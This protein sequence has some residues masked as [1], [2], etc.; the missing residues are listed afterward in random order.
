M[1][2][3]ALITLAIFAAASFSGCS[4]SDKAEFDSLPDYE[5]Y[6]EYSCGGAEITAFSVGSDG[7]L[8]TASFYPNNPTEYY[9][10]CF[11]M[12]GAK[13]ASLTTKR[14]ISAFSYDDNT[15][16]GAF[17]DSGTFLEELDLSS[18]EYREIC[19]LNEFDTIKK[20]QSD[21]SDI[22]VMGT[23]FDR[24][25]LDGEYYDEFGRYRYN[26]EMLLRI[27]RSSGE[28]TQSP[29]SY[30]AAFSAKN[31][32]CRVY[33]ADRDGL[34]FCDFDGNERMSHDIIS[35][36]GFDLYGRE[37]Y[38]FT[39]S[40]GIYVGNVCAG[41]LS[42]DDG[43]SQCFD[44]T[45]DGT[46]LSVGGYTFFR[47]LRSAESE[48]YS[49]IIRLKNSSYIK[50]NNKIK[51]ISSTLDY[52]APFGCGYTID[53]ENLTN[54]QL[55]LSILSNDSNYDISAVSSFA[56]CAA[57][58][59]DKGSFYPLSNIPGVKEY[60]DKCLPCIKSA[61]V[62]SEGEVWMLPV[63]LDAPI[64]AY[65]K[66]YPKSFDFENMTAEEFVLLCQSL[67]AEG[68][69]DGYSVH[70]YLYTRYL[71]NCLASGKTS[72][73]TPELTDFL[74]FAKENMNISVIPYPDYF[75]PV[76]SAMNDYMITGQGLD[77]FV[78]SLPTQR[79]DIEWYSKRDF[80][81][82][83]APRISTDDSCT[84][85]CEFLVVN[86]N[87][88]NL[89]ET[90]NYISSLCCFLSEKDSFMLSDNLKERSGELF[91]VLSSAEIGFCLSDEILFEPYLS[92]L[93]GELSESAFIDEANRRL[94]AYLNE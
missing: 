89:D 6:Y 56:D 60:L 36:N 91:N 55:A 88:A 76:N 19:P 78:F 3:T 21:G 66:S 15:I 73:G 94:S 35:M 63:A 70:A 68:R 57:N 16:I 46:L 83:P 65:N 14:I 37:N 53:Y 13:T 7:T 9:I 18:G 51:L 39:A 26:G 49:K 71:L 38:V 2:K 42:I 44:S 43:I 1:R 64:I 82:A 17:S 87:S 20:V 23:A 61:A 75:P 27:D 41:S 84:A 33:A 50:G 8:C 80:G 32:I 69:T 4:K 28:K 79:E 5:E 81:F 52:S 77:N 74:S 92:F 31:N 48:D 93:R 40:T 59:R 47:H 72:V 45:T 10:D 54:E 25:M 12:D 29:V 11:D 22:Y 85:S 58:I 67:K 30:P 86:P 90:L 24:M 34:Y 62:D